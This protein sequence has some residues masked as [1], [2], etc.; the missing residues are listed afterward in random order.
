MSEPLPK[1]PFPPLLRY[2]LIVLGLVLLSFVAVQV[3][4]VWNGA[5][6]PVAVR[7][8]PLQVRWY[9][10]ILMCGA[11]SGALLG[12]REARR[13]GW[14]PDHV[15][16]LLL[17]GLIAGVV[18]ARLWYVLGDPNLA[19]DPLAIVGVVN[20]QFVGLQGLTIHG[21]LIGALGAALAYTAVKRQNFFAWIDVGAV[22]FVLGQAVGRWGNFFNHEAYG[23]PTSLPWGLVIPAAYRIAPYT[24]MA[25]YPLSTR[26][27]PAFLYES[28]WNI[29]VC[30]LLLY[31]GRRFAKRMIPG[32]VFWLYGMLYGLGRF[33]LEFL[34]ADSM[35]LPGNLPKFPA[36]QAV[37]VL[38]FLMC[39]ALLV[40]RRW[41]WRRK[42]YAEIEA[43]E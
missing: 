41:I 30:F 13:R 42:T 8:G 7:L 32:E 35:L 19:R 23:P 17:W 27:H 6:D 12:E 3:V 38:L 2:A 15:W 9:G 39:G 16:N 34:R 43:K 21:A 14:D 4:R 25:R 29:G 18:V 1:K 22:G 5:G 11:L 24:D 26:F 37:S 36:A 10:I 40:S 28:L 31:L 20:G 33:F